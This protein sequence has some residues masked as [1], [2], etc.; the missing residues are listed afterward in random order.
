MF[1][2]ALNQIIEKKHERELEDKRDDYI[3]KRDY[4]KVYIIANEGEITE[5]KKG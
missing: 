1:A 2:N 5:L 3:L 4:C